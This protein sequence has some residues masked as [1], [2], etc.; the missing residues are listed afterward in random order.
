MYRTI[1]TC[2]WDCIDSDRPQWLQSHIKTGR[3]ALHRQ[4]LASSLS[5]IQRIII[6][7]RHA[8]HHRLH[9]Y[10]WA[11]ASKCSRSLQTLAG[12][13][14]VAQR[15]YVSAVSRCSLMFSGPYTRVCNDRI[16]RIPEVQ[17]DQSSTLK[18]GGSTTISRIDERGRKGEEPEVD[19]RGGLLR[20]LDLVQFVREL[21]NIVLCK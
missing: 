16:K 5:Y 19:A 6:R 20:L 7:G 3:Q 13:C 21:H 1:S 9:G 14:D 8:L 11:R 10:A 12:G 4:H 15:D 17:Y 2:W 18:K